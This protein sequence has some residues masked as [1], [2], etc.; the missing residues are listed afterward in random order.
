MP[1]MTTEKTKKI[2]DRFRLLCD[3]STESGEFSE[4][5]YTEIDEGC[6]ELRKSDDYD[7]V[8]R[9]NGFDDRGL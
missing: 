3:Q 8:G 6:N 9:G 5:A 1:N 4:D 2:L 7:V